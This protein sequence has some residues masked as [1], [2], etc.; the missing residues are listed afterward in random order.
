[1]FASQG[2]VEHLLR[3]LIGLGALVGAVVWGPAHPVVAL[4]LMAVG[5]VALRGCP[6]CWTVGLVQTV[7]AA[8]RAFELSEQRLNAGTIDI[9]TVLNTEQTLFQAEDSLAQARLTR[10]QAVISLYQALG[11]GWTQTTEGPA[12]AI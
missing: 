4:L 5:L 10:V 8:R 11:G 6:M 1:M 12:D 7:A 2:L 3:G 9:T